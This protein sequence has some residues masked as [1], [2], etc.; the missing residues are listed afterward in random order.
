[1][2]HTDDYIMLCA[3]QMFGN[4]KLQINVRQTELSRTEMY[5][6]NGP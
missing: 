6:N 2:S 3:G 1:M 5:T 4:G